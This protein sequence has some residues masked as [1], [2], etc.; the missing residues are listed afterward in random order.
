MSMPA[1]PAI[2]AVGGPNHTADHATTYAIL[3]DLQSAVAALQG[4]PSQFALNGGNSA[5]VPSGTTWATVTVQPGNTA[6][7][8]DIY[9][10]QQKIFSLNSYGEPRITAAA[11]TH[12][13]EIIYVLSGQSADAWQ[14]L[15][16]SL[17]VLARVGPNGA[18][19]FAGPVSRQL[20]GGPASWVHPA[21]A[22]GWTAYAGRTLAVKLT[23]D[24]MV[25]ITGEVAPGTVQDGISIA[26]LP[27]GYAPIR[28]EPVWVGQH[29]AVGTAGFA[30]PYL[31]AQPG[32]N[33]LLYSFGPFINYGNPHMVIAGRY[34]LDA[35]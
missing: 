1:P 25:Q 12:V 5:N 15:S 26:V 20:A 21:M 35:S 24:N 14:I 27:A 16:S 9:Y 34:P 17:A 19:S 3:G 31:E 22:N 6:D 32:G 29:N 23:N 2:P 18:A 11:L 8:L 30:G 10:G 33:L 13:A 4:Q 28:P 7:V